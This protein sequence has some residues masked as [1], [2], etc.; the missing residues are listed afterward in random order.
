[1]TQTMSEKK[2]GYTAR[3]KTATSEDINMKR[4]ITLCFVLFCLSSYTL[5]AQSSIK[6]E[7]TFD[8]P[9]LPPGWQ[10]IDMDQGG[11]SLQLVRST[12]TGDGTDILPQA[13][14]YFV[15]GNV[16]DAN[17]AGII[18][19]WL[20]SPQISVI[21][22]GD[23]LYFWAGA[24]GDLF[25]DSL[26]VL[27]STT[28]G[29]PKDFSHELGRFKVDG[30]AG[31]WHRYGFDL[32][33]FDS[34]DIY[35]AINYLI[36]DGGPGGANSD[37][38]WIDHT[39][40]SGDPATLNAPPTMVY[41]KS[42]ADKS[43]LDFTADTVNFSWSGSTDADNDTLRYTLSIV[44]VF[45]VLQF[46]GIGDT[47]FVFNW[48]DILN[49][50]MDYRWTVRVTD[51]KSKVAS[52]DTFTFRMSNPAAVSA[53][54]IHLPDKSALYQNYPN[55]FNPTTRISYDLKS[56]AKVQLILYNM[57][58]QKV[59]TLV[60][61]RKPAGRYNREFDGSRLASGVYIYQIVISGA[62]ESFTANRKMVLI[63]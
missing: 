53:D 19:E 43:K 16:Q 14:Q 60:D 15:T 29:D 36:I 35:F 44:N 13:G 10:M 55:P 38:V 5:F 46:T 6:W 3:K 27:V 30:P 4:P 56:A 48:K 9:V 24:S 49:E 33:A 31:S 21:Y 11:A 8:A 41:L 62:E 12:K 20:I 50:D 23:S 37:F 63:R 47:V 59:V 25:A 1:M 58:G 17:L 57:L 2:C 40:I 45:P 18:D 39:V 34:A 26:R 51:G 52:P 42:P 61:G 28:G 54:H 32:S 7:E 22:A